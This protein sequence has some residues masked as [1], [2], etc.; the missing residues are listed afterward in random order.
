MCRRD[1]MKKVFIL[2]GITMF[3][4]VF[5]FPQDYKGRAR[6]SGIVLDESGKPLEG[7]SVKLVHASLNQGFN[8]VTDSE[9]I[10]VASWIKGGSW[11]IDFEKKGYVPKKIGIKVKEG[12]RNPDVEIILE[13]TEGLSLTSALKEKLDQANAFYEQEKFDAA[14]IAYE[15]IIEEFPDVHIINANIGNCFF[16]KGEYDKAIIYYKKV[17]EKDPKNYEAKMYIGNSYS[18]KGENNK[19][20]EWYNKIDFTD[21]QDVNVL[22]NIGTDFYSASKFSE[23]IKYY[24]KAV[25]LKSD[26]LDALYQLG[27]AYLSQGNNQEAMAVFENYLEQDSNSQRAQQVQD[28]IAYLKK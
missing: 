28:F 16:E 2:F 12:V 25:E 14:I 6:L 9:G 4:I 21:I 5:L 20:Q 22:Y 7:V 24:K 10:W 13:Q 17:L 3:L 1:D 11:N 23:A 26:F 27:L 8:V 15:A 19:A 18:N